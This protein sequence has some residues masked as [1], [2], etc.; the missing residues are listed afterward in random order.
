[1]QLED[2]LVALMKV[3][4]PRVYPSSAPAS[5]PTPYVVWQHIGG[6]P[7]RF[8]DNTAGDKRNANIQVNVWHTNVKAAFTLIRAIE[9]GLCA[10]VDKLTVQPLSEPI[11]GFDDSN[12]LQGALQSFSIWG[13]R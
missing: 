2:E 11:D 9:D 4:C 3:H 10:A 1:M 6:T 13:P 12:E 5:T 7:F 8:F